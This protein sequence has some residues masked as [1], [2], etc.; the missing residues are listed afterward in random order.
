MKNKVLILVQFSKRYDP[1]N[2]VFS[3]E[4]YDFDK[5]KSNRQKQIQKSLNS[6]ANSQSSISNN[7]G[8][9][10][11]TL[12]RQGSPKI[13]Q[14][15]IDKLNEHKKNSFIVLMSEIFPN[16]LKLFENQIDW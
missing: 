4:Y 6:S 12:G 13:M 1:Y 14:N 16:K 9:I 11:S 15:L 8:L 3:H 5:M 7:Y 2:K 10:L